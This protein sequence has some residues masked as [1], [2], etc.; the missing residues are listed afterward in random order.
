MTDPA[1]EVSLV[2]PPA[3]P[4]G[5]VRCGSA[6]SDSF[7]DLSPTGSLG[8]KLKY[9]R[10]RRPSLQEWVRPV[11]SSKVDDGGHPKPPFA[12]RKRV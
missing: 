1:V 2:A 9:N 5:L 12:G 6:T 10:D 4:A 11:E 8:H 7:P 3:I